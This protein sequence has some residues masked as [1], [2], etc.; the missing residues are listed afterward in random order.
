[1]AIL[2]DANALCAFLNL[3]IQFHFSLPAAYVALLENDDIDRIVDFLN[4]R[5]TLRV[6]RL[7]DRITVEGG[8]CYVGHTK[9]FVRFSVATN[10]PT[11]L[12][13]SDYVAE[14]GHPGQALL[15]TIAQEMKEQSMGIVLGQI[16]S[17]TAAG[18]EAVERT[19]GK[20]LHFEVG[21]DGNNRLLPGIDRGGLEEMGRQVLSQ[22][23]EIL[24]RG[25]EHD[26][27]VLADDVDE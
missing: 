18:M 10:Q 13:G 24:D 6:L 2:A 8:C 14:A 16:D 1:M 25:I 19:G 9:E 7:R 3:I 21:L 27:P 4:I 20:A 15:R 23:Q 5:S 17:A 22:L 11:L 12:V 26:A